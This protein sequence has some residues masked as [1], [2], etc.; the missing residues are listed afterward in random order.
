MQLGESQ[1][2]KHD[3]NLLDSATEKAIQPVSVPFG[4]TDVEAMIGPHDPV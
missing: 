3:P 2:P 1:G 4:Q